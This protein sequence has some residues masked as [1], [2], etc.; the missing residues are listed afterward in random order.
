MTD[1]D[2]G[3]AARR[4]ARTNAYLRLVA[5]EGRE[6]LKV[7]PFL[8]TFHPSNDNPYVNY[9]IPDDDARPAPSDI[10][11]FVAEAR[12]RGRKPRLEY[13]PLAAPAVETALL[14]AGF[15]VEMRPAFMTCDAPVALIPPPGFRARMV[16]EAGDLRAAA[17]VL[18]LA[19]AEHGQ[20]PM[21]DDERL[22]GFTSGG[23]GVALATSAETG[24]V[25]GAGLFTAIA[26]GMTEVAGIGVAPAFRRRGLA[27]IL[28]ATLTGETF[29]R[30]AS[31]AFLTPGGDHARRAYERAGFRA[32][33]EML[34]IGLA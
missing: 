9:A 22:M 5:P 30:G 15:A 23:G 34:M 29:R 18:D 1:D 16:R 6:A 19:Y 27:S 24:E 33:G 28:A 10:A 31:L 13:A 4:D 11:A 3:R 2:P 21:D 20:P 17:H 8:A 25:A 14:A 32:G 26:E 7:G 12:R